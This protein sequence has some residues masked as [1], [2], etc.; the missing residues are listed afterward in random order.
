[1]PY[2]DPPHLALPYFL[3]F[4]PMAKSSSFIRLRGTC[5][6]RKGNDAFRKLGSYFVTRGVYATFEGDELQAVLRKVR[7]FNTFTK[8]NDPWN[9]HDFGSFPH[10]GET[11]FWKID[12]HDSATAWKLQQYGVPLQCDTLSPNQT[13]RVL[14]VMLAEEY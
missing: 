3:T 13:H 9:E 1:M 10:N 7:D 11:I 8:D 14:T 12:H 2:S 4:I 5:A 6:I